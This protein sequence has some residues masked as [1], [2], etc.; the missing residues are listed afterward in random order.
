MKMKI[1]KNIT[2]PYTPLQRGNKKSNNERF[3]KNS[4][5]RRGVTE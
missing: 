2:H 1:K 3:L 5:Q 4:L